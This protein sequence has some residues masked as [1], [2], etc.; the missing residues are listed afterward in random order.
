MTPVSQESQIYPPPNL[1]SYQ[2]VNNDSSFHS[3]DLTPK[4]SEHKLNEEQNIH[5]QL[6]TDL[7]QVQ[8]QIVSTPLE[9][10]DE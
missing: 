10:Y 5:V 1:E 9:K 2:F 6:D 4:I 3:P 7:S 8:S